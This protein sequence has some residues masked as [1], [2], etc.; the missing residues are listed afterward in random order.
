MLSCG[1]S[2][3]LGEGELHCTTR[4]SLKQASPAWEETTEVG[5]HALHSLPMP[6]CPDFGIYFDRPKSALPP[7]SLPGPWI[8]EAKAA[9]SEAAESILPASG[10]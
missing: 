4:L 8:A 5:D 1:H 7:C 3:Q 6:L 10:S 2:V 9:V